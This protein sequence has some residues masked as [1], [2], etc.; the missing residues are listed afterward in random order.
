MA[1]PDPPAVPEMDAGKIYLGVPH[2]GGREPASQLD[3]EQRRIHETDRDVQFQD[4]EDA[5]EP[6][7]V[8]DMGITTIEWGKLGV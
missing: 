6:T 3:P 7:I 8:T 4:P 1:L 2:C 5:A